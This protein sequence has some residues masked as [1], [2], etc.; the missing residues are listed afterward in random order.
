MELTQSISLYNQKLTENEFK[1]VQ[2]FMLNNLGVKLA[3]IKIVMVNS[4]LIKRLRATGIGSFSDYLDYALSA[5]GKQSGEL[6]RMIDELT[7]H[8]TEFFRES[9]H[10]VFME[11]KALPEFFNQGK[12]HFKIW[13]AGCSSGEEPYTMSIVLSEFALKNR[14]FDFTVHASDVSQGVLT[15]AVRAIYSYD[16]I[17]DMDLQLIKRYFLRNRDYTSNEVRVSKTL[18]DKVHFFIQN[19][20]D[21]Y[22][23]PNDSLDMV[24]CRNTL[25]YFDEK[26]KTDVV[27]RLIRKIRPG[28][29]LIVGLSETVSQFSTAI[30][31]VQPSVYVKVH[32]TVND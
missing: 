20:V 22:P 11:N 13:S 5:E 2:D 3:P 16:S 15:T 24:F 4:R 25:I 7:T 31:Q 12:T 1:R 6:E 26:S 18:R 27:N 17:N 23:F 32:N 19:L 28:G 21:E 30:K 14:N 9:D 10:Y 29:Y 8:K